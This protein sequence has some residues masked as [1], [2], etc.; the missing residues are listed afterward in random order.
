MALLLLACCLPPYFQNQKNKEVKES[1]IA[2]HC[3]EHSVNEIVFV[4]SWQGSQQKFFVLYN[5]LLLVLSDEELTC[6]V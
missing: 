4:I 6:G 1:G 5:L 2:S 3:G